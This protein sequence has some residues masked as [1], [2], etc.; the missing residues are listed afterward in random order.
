MP[1][2]VPTRGVD[3][4][5]SSAQRVVD[6]LNS[7]TPLTDWSV[8][9]VAGGEQV[10]LHVHGEVG[11]EPGMR[12]DWNDTLCR[13]MVDGA[14][15][16]VVDTLAD[17]DYSDHAYAGLIRAYAG[18]PL[19][20]D[21]GEMFGVLCGFGIEPL[22]STEE[23]DGDL[24]ALMGGLLSTQLVAAR[25]ADRGRRDVEIAEALAQTD[26]L[27]GL[28][29]RRGWDA[30]VADAEQRMNAYGDLVAVAVI[31]LDGLKAVN[32]SEGHAAGDR[33]IAAAANALAG[34]A[35]EGDRVARYG[36]DEFAVLAN[37]VAVADLPEHVGAYTRALEAAGIGASMGWA[38]GSP[39]VTSVAD[40]F[41]GADRAM[42]MNK[43]ER[44]ADPR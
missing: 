41:I 32:D 19:T 28:T 35:H 38:I 14:A 31:D 12:V 3:L 33:L 37:S 42:Y 39:S 10:H 23:I 44:K 7:H 1:S 15:P 43:T 13:R 18:V 27:T 21:T 25:T 20:D 29:N 40:A 8:T 6:Y 22:T 2:E 30:L 9:R 11:V 4:F 36:G 26:P 5:T 34:V 24:V 17:P 16:V